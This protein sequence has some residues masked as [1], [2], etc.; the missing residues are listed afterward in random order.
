MKFYNREKELQTLNNYVGKGVFGYMTGRRRIGKTALLKR[1]CELVNGVY[2]Q[3][4]TG[5][6]QQQLEYLV[7]DIKASIKPFDDLK[8]KTWAE[9][10][11]ILSLADSLPPVIIFDEFPFWVAADE[12]LPSVLQKWIDHELPKK[13]TELIVA[14]SSQTM[15][16]SQF[17]KH[18]APLYGRS[19][20]HLHLEPL[21]YRFFCKARCLQMKDPESFRLYSLVGGI[22]HY[23]RLL[24]NRNILEEV[25]SLYFE[26]SAILSDEPLTLLRDEGVLGNTPAAI[27]GLIG[28]GVARS[29]EMAARMGVPQGNLSKPLLQLLDLGLICRQLPFGETLKTSK[30]VLYTIIDPALAFYY[31]T[32]LP[33]RG[34]WP[35][36]SKKEQQNL[37][38]LHTSHCWE[39][40]CRQVFPT[41]ERYWDV[42]A[43]IDFVAYLSK[44]KLLVAECKWK[45][46][47]KQQE[48]DLVDNLKERFQ[49]TKLAQKYSKIQFRIF[50]QSNIAELADSEQ[51]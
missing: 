13:A 46:L 2:H 50:S 33:H 12:T 25:E 29:G 35:I 22:P 9:F 21:A 4:V 17:L 43:E 10:F 32:V 11:K 34:R 51:N 7:D 36:Y 41:A 44:D 23:W 5:T 8:P 26:P 20:F 24:N 16:Y 37:L 27:L 47:S 14:G 42:N 30:R 49:K 45:K 1:F 48:K 28:K 15:M 3:A 39:N 18:D 19:L 6:T 31:G 40:Y 38:N